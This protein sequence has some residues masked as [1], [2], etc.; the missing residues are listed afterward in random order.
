MYH[1]F[2]LFMPVQDLNKRLSLPADI[3]IPDGYLEKLQMSSPP[4][5][6]PLSR[7]SRRASLVSWGGRK[8]ESD[9]IWYGWGIWKK[10]CFIAPT[11]VYS[12]LPLFILIC[13]SL[14]SSHL[15]YVTC[16]ALKTRWTN[17]SCGFEPCG[18]YFV[19]SHSWYWC[20]K[21]EC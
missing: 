9:Q 8:T 18:S 3:R 5:D 10:I 2:Y 11:V 21:N 6:Q 15:R 20:W 7:R 4:F 16:A 19:R 13:C 17:N 12:Y 14:N 1:C